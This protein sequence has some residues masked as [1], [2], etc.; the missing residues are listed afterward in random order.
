[1]ILIKIH[2]ATRKVISLKRLSYVVPPSSHSALRSSNFRRKEKKLSTPRKFC[3]VP[4]IIII[5]FSACAKSAKGR[6]RTFRST[7]E[8]RLFQRLVFR[9]FVQ[10]MILLF[11]K[12]VQLDDV[13]TARSVTEHV[14][15]KDCKYFELL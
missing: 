9:P 11:C 14:M 7:F 1:M 6:P 4:L 2:N 10:C 3:V 15:T 8:F 13:A 12:I 5:C